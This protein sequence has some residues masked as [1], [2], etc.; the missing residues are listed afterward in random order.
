MRRGASLLALLPILAGCPGGTLPIEPPAEG[1]TDAPLDCADLQVGS[2]DWFDPAPSGTLA[3]S[4]E[5]GQTQVVRPDDPRRA[6]VTLADR[7][8][9]LLFTPD[10]PIDADARVSAWDGDTLLGVVPLA[11]P[12][13]LPP[14]LEQSLT[15]AELE[16]Y[17]T[18]AWS[19]ALPAGWVQ[20]GIDLQIGTADA[21]HTHTLTDLGAPTTFTMTR[22]HIVLFGE[23]DKDTTTEP[24]ERLAQDLFAATPVA[25]LR[26]VDSLP[27]R[28]SEIVVQ[29]DDGPRLVTSE[30]ERRALVGE[31]DHWSILKHQLA[32]RHSLANTGRGLATTTASDGDSSP[33]S[34][35]TSL[36][37]GWFLDPEGVYQD[38]DDA[39]WA[40]GW[41]G[42]SAIWLSECGNTIA[43]EVGHSYT[44][45][46]FVEGTAQS[47]GIA[48]EYP[49]DG[50]HTAEHPWG[51]DST[52]DLLR[53]WYRVDGAGPVED[54]GSFVGKRDPMNGGEPA[55]S[56][57]CFPQYTGYHAEKIQSWLQDSPTLMELDGEAA[58][59]QWDGAQFV[60]IAAPE[61]AQEPIGVGVPVIT[62]VGAL[63]AD[64]DASRT[65]PP[66]H[67]AS[68]NVFELPDPEAATLPASYTGAVWFL[69]IERDD[70]TVENALI[71][72]GPLQD[73]DFGLYSVNLAADPPIVRV[74]LMQSATPFPNVDVDG[75]ELVHT[76][77]LDA[78][79]G[80]LPDVVTVG[81]GR[82]ANGGL[83]LTDRCEP[84]V[85]CGLRTARS[86]WRVN[87]GQLHF[88]ADGVDA[89]EDC[90]EVNGWT[91][92]SVPVIDTDGATA[93]LT[94]EAQRVVSAGGESIA[95]PI[96]DITPWIDAPDLEQALQ[97]RIP[98]EAN[99]GLSE[100]RWSVD[101]E[102]AIEARLDG[103]A[104]AS[105]PLTI[106][107]EVLATQTVDL[108]SEWLSAELSTP[109]SSMYFLVRDPSVGP[110]ERVW[111]GDAGPTVLR[112][113]VVDDSGA[114]ATMVVNA[115]Q[116]SCGSRWELNAG[117]GADA[118]THRAVLQRADDPELAA[119]TTWRT[120]AS[121]PLVID[122]RRWHD[123]DA[124]LLIDT[125]AL[126]L[127]VTP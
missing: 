86:A 11:P 46:H 55:N 113:P 120:P 58:V 12:E 1:P 28:L 102:F 81:R 114:V 32:L 25:E 35:G 71:A 119:G 115:W 38:I 70:G 88:D 82:I 27:W 52:R 89:P 111:W 6:P 98:W 4:I 127:E 67:A 105:V 59:V 121:A 78:P 118:C 125:F 74:D 101:G 90:L 29:T 48:D 31:Q 24:A 87:D 44:L 110:T 16:P 122:G 106:D 117:R 17:S 8:T 95:V 2:L 73:P 72:E 97:V 26:W 93:T 108:A 37:L 34:F 50:V 77:V 62:L 14:L 66:I 63:G 21:V 43:H 18:T 56:V 96:N 91:A 40:A 54:G 15:V 64:P 33:Y 30:A 57:T 100:G 126:D 19:A 85:N 22:T 112:V 107:L 99:A 39:P 65:Y 69:A 103:A 49:Q 53:T 3:G 92:L 75:A 76:L 51:Y 79:E 13:E 42:W 83:T 47:W 61:G 5:L 84:G 7:Q 10:A 60:R 104:F 109:E 45:A 80:P 41:T 116:E 36:G 9:L 94:I 23:G 123:P 68:G 124:R 20:E